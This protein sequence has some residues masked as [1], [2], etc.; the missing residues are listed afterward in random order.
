MADEI[1]HG[2]RQEDACFGFFR[3]VV[4]KEDFSEYAENRKLVDAIC[5]SHQSI[6][7]KNMRQS[8]SFNEGSCRE[9]RKHY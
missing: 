6:H 7:A 9:N 8:R 2:K 4:Q 1:E 3:R 5:Q